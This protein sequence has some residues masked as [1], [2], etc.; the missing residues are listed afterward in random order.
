M[1]FCQTTACFSDPSGT[2]YRSMDYKDKNCFYIWIGLNP[3][4]GCVWASYLHTL[5]SSKPNTTL[6]KCHCLG[7]IMSR[8]KKITTQWWMWMLFSSEQR[9]HK[10]THFRPICEGDVWRMLGKKERKKEALWEGIV[11]LLLIGLLQFL[12]LICSG[13]L[14]VEH[15]HV[16]YIICLS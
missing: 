6:H 16:W 12:N 3:G 9:K 2:K 11:S 13:L 10:L 1:I 5:N 14:P 4:P 15:Y 8:N 7:I